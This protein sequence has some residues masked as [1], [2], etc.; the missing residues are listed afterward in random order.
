MPYFITLYRDYLNM[1]QDLK[2][3][4]KKKAVLEPRDLKVQHDLFASR[5]AEQKEAERNR[6]LNRPID[7][8]VY[9]WA[10]EY[11]GRDFMVV[12]PK[13]RA[14]FI[15]EGQ[16]LNHCV[17][18]TG[19]FN[20][21]LRGRQMVFFIRK[22]DQPDRPYFTTEIDVENGRILQLYGFADCSAPKEV[23][24]FVEGFVKAIG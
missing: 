7:E 8:S 21:H 23:R 15:R 2:S 16:C 3:D 19:Y 10:Q 11:T 12:Y 17:G 9:W 14:D 4:M 20:R 1:A 22:A 24:A 6:E 5:I 18:N 13:C